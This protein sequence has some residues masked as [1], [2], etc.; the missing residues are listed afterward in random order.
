MSKNPTKTHSDPVE[1][2]N[3]FNDG[4]NGRD[5]ERLSSL[6]A[7]H[8][9]FIDRDGKSYGP[10]SFMV[11]G[12]KNFFKSFP[13]YRNT[14][15]KIKVK[16]GWVYVLGFAYWTKEEPYDPVIWT[17]R[18]ENDLITEWRIDVDTPESREKFGFEQER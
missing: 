17:A 16:A 6:M 4:I 10:K 12:W 18:I 9:V 2:V 3:R 13:D 11:E 15:E 8:H 1:I 14:F 7:E 5:I